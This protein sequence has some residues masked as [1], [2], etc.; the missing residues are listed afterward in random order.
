MTHHH[1]ST[2]SLSRVLACF[3]ACLI[4]LPAV[5]LAT[6]RATPA[7][8]RTEQQQVGSVQTGVNVRQG[9]GTSYD[10]VAKIRE[11]ETCTVLGEDGDWYKVLKDGETGYV[12][13]ELLTVETVEVEVPVI[14]EDPLEATLNDFE[15]E[16]LLAYRS[17]YQVNGIVTSNIPMTGI[18]V[19]IYDLRQLAVERSTSVAFAHD[20]DVREYDL[21][22][23]ADN[24]SFRKLDPGEKQ[25]VVTVQSANEELEIARIF[26]YVYGQCEPTVHMTD[27]CEVEMS[28]GSATNILDYN[29]DTNWTFY[30]DDDYIKISIPE[31]Q[32]P[33]ALTLEWEYAPKDTKIVLTDADGAELGVITEENTGMMQRYYELDAR[34]RH[35]EVT[36]TDEGN[37]MVE[38]R[39]YEE[40]KIASMVQNWEPLPEKVD[41]MLIVA[42]KNDE[43]LSLGGSMTFASLNGKT[44]AVVY[45]T[46]NSRQRYA[47]GLDGMWTCGLKNYPIFLTYE[48]EKIR[49]YAENIRLWGDGALSDIVEVI[50]R[51]K[52]DV[53]ITH[54]IEGEFGHKQHVLTCDLVRQA[55][56]ITADPTQE[57]ESAE[58]YGVWDVP[59]LYIHL[60]EENRL[61]LPWDEPREEL[62]GFTINEWNY[63][64]FEK[65]WCQRQYYSMDGDGKTYDCTCFGLYRSTVGPDVE[66]NSFFE[67]LD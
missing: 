59:K 36:T 3:L 4:F 44:C 22:R 43:L 64:A 11:G 58:K 32:T 14:I 16:K 57:A 33:A 6:D 49:N 21:D 42:H 39:V 7:Y 67:N 50:R 56:E 24:L 47:E 5:A 37:A 12:L 27:N 63:V 23:L 30:D 19:D 45:M 41:L 34:T 60:Y 9:P 54:D 51:Y 31:G 1:N 8:Y 38:L 65:H 52:P 46:E 66:K 61:T 55:V 20:D 62:G 15:W 53:I 25:L 13:K 10:S 17:D 2:R 18:T 48:D 26:F 35:I 29:Y 28:H 40:G